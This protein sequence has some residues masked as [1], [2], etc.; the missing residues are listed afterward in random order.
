MWV[1]RVRAVVVVDE[2]GRI[3]IPKEIRRALRIQRGTL[4]ELSVEGGEIRMRPLKSIA[5][6]CFGKYR[7]KRWP[8]DLDSF[9]VEVMKKW[10]SESTST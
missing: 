7:V 8:E 6:E 3:V 1:N 5:E 2:R 10:W 9:L 4:L